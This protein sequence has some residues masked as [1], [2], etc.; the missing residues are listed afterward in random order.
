MHPLKQRQ[1]V[2]WE[3]SDCALH[4]RC[5]DGIFED[6][7]QLDVQVR[8]SRTG[9]VQLFI[10]VYLGSGAMKF[11]EYYKDRVDESMTQALEWGIERAL[12]LTSSKLMPLSS[13]PTLSVYHDA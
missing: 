2:F 13:S 1:R 5:H 6:G 4:T 11:E 7:G 12:T 8:T 10:G 3:W 9:V